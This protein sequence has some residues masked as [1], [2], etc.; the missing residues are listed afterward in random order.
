MSSPNTTIRSGWRLWLV[1]AFLTPVAL[2]LQ[3][4]D[5]HAQL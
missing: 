4:R 5:R 1:A 2:Y 3:W